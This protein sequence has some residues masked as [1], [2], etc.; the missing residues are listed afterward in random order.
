M[1]E[2][3]PQYASWKAALEK[4]FGKLRDGAFLIGHSI[5]ATI[6]INALAEYTAKWTPGGVFLISA[7][8]VGKGGWP[9]ENMRPMSDLGA[10]L[11]A[12][13]PLYLYYGGN[14]DTVPAAH[15]GLYER[16]IPA[17][18]IRQLAGRDHQLDNNLSEVAADMR[19]PG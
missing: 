17:A 13:V 6:L 11:P 12:G 16:A 9:A 15:V 8:F 14:D 10:R 4:E 18:V 2:S 5:G 7:P 1:G 19:A 3:D